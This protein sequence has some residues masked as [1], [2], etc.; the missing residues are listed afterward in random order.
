MNYYIQVLEKYATFS[1]RSQR[2]E[3]WIFILVN[4]LIGAISAIISIA[5]NTNIM[6]KFVLFYT[7]AIAIPSIAVAVRRLHD[8]GRSGWFIF[9]ELIPIVGSIVLLI[10]MAQDSQSGANKYGQNPKEIK[11]S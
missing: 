5:L 4:A 10:F 1:G 8:T 2:K 11:V 9:L 3:F 6:G 7:L